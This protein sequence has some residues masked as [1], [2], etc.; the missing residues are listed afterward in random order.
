MMYDEVIAGIGP[1]V[2]ADPMAATVIPPGAFE[3][4]CSLSL[5]LMTA[6]FL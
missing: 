6:P 3:K 2:N 5:A 4:M 1:M